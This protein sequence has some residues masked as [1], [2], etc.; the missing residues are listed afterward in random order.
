[1][2]NAGTWQRS[3]RGALACG[4]WRP[5]GQKGDIH[6]PTGPVLGALENPEPHGCP[7]PGVYGISVL[8]E[9]QLPNEVIWGISKGVETS[10]HQEGTD[11]STPV[12]VWPGTLLPRAFLSSPGYCAWRGS[13]NLRCFMGQWLRARSR[14][15]KTS[16]G[17]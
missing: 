2:A 15:R 7:A 17:C 16:S 8:M 9:S 11:S 12:H 1:M 3:V 14:F 5:A 4:H 13:K 10:H 6:V